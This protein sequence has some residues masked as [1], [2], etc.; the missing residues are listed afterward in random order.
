MR[1]ERSAVV[2]RLA[3]LVALA[4]FLVA[5]GSAAGS[6]TLP[7]C[8]PEKYGVDLKPMPATADPQHAVRLTVGWVTGME[9]RRSCSLRTTIRLKISGSDGVV[10]SAKWRVHTV[11]HPWSDIVHTW[12]WR[13]WCEE[14]HGEARVKVSDSSGRTLSQRI[15]GPPVCASADAATTVT[16]LGTGTRYVKRPSERIPPHMLPKGTPPR[17][18]WR[19]LN[20]K[21]AWIV[22]NGY[23]LVV[24]YAGSPGGDPSLGRFA[25]VRQ[26]LI[27][28]VQYDPPDLVDVGK[29]GAIRIT[30][31]PRGRSRETTAQHGRIEFVSANG[32]RGVLELIGDHVRITAR[33]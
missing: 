32:T 24:V 30:R 31:A 5:V 22:G 2:T 11:R 27:F 4:S 25:I 7:R 29:V 21:N 12:V 3:L 18:Q 20:P 8:A 17:T 16:N 1:R 13:N 9:N 28:G 33:P 14:K 23:T 6:T 15:A 26:N 10:A 19:D